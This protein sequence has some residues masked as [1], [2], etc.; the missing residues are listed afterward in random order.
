VAA[1]LAVLT[2]VTAAMPAAPPTVAVVVARQQ[3]QGGTVLADGDLEVRQV[4]A[5]DLPHGHV[6]TVDGLLGRTLAAPA[7][8]GQVLTGLALVSARAAAGPGQ[9][10]APLRLADAGLA[11]LLQPGD[12]VDVLAAD[13]QAGQARVVARS[14]RVITIPAVPEDG[15]AETAGTLVLLAVSPSTATELAQAAVTGP[16]TVTWR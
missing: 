4:A 10:V 11:T 5:A 14:V 9:V 3:L 7:A 12:V 8:E 1:A 6:G 16:L 2:G 15:S 13:E